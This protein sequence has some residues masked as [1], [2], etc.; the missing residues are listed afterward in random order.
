MR[1]LA[2]CACMYACTSVCLLFVWDVCL[3]ACH[4]IVPILSANRMRPSLREIEVIVPL[5]WC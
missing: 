2:V 4:G 1:S 5:A 3:C